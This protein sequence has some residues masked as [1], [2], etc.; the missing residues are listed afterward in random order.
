MQFVSNY[1]KIKKYMYLPSNKDINVIKI[2]DIRYDNICSITIINIFS[3]YIMFSDN[4][5]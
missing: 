4:P 2:M 3:I 1:T 5:E